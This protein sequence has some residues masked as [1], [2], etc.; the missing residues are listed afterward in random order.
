[1]IV[2]TKAG[3]RFLVDTDAK[4]ITVRKMDKSC[5]GS[6]YY[7][8]LRLGE[9]MELLCA[10]WKYISTSKVISIEEER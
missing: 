6:Y 10:P 4:T 3:S 5:R 9:P 1:M 2:T 7:L 8:R